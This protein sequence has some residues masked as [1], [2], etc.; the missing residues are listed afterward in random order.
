MTFKI[1]LR[2]CQ[3]TIGIFTIGQ[4][5]AQNSCLQ[6]YADCQ[7]LVEFTKTDLDA[8][9]I[10]EF[11]ET[12]PD[13]P[14][15]FITVLGYDESGP[16]LLLG[17]AYWNYVQILT[18]AIKLTS[19]KEYGDSMI[20]RMITCTDG[21][22]WQADGVAMLHN[23]FYTSFDNPYITMK[24]LTMLESRSSVSQL[25]FWRFYFEPE[26]M[27]QELPTPLSSYLDHDEH[28]KTRDLVRFVMNERFKH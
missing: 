10:V 15:D 18:A 1:L 13:I 5:G 11:I 2:L 6:T 26:G 7:I 16:E 22:S 9:N 14:E 4:T 25:A 20:I 12:F 17:C 28:A 3:F 23:Y 19:N 27:K 8:E 21:L 24:L